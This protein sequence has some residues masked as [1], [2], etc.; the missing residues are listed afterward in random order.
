MTAQ[1][2]TPRTGYEKIIEYFE[3]LR[4][5][6]TRETHKICFVGTQHEIYDKMI[7]LFLKE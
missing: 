4:S 6:L 1:E 3:G 7:D 5:R 2:N